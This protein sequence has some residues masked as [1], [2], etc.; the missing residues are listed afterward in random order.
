M[1][2]YP[3]IRRGSFD[4]DITRNLEDKDMGEIK[5]GSRREQWAKV[6][7]LYRRVKLRVHGGTDNRD[8]DNRNYLT[9]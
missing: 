4:T 3:R 9:D 2:L 8:G 1:N 5:L 7:H 6:Q